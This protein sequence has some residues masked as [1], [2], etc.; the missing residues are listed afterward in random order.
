V[1]IYRGQRSEPGTRSPGSRSA[2]SR[3]Q[4]SL[5]GVQQER[6]TALDIATWLEEEVRS[7]QGAAYYQVPHRLADLAPVIAQ[8]L[9]DRLNRVSWLEAEIRER[10]S[11]RSFQH[12]DK[13]AEAIRMISDCDLWR[14][15]AIATNTSAKMVKQQL[16]AIV[17]RRNQI[18]HEADLDPTFGL[19]NRWPIDERL[20]EE[21]VSF[22]EQVVEAIHQ[23]L[24]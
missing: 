5:G 20:T 21:A 7:Q 12:P 11:Y 18:A 8:S 23:L 14:E 9:R 6:Q 17:D 16:A 2:W 3:F 22:I 24:E 10:L 1:A 13:I 4:V 15:V 19:G